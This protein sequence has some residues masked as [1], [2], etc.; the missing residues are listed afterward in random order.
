MMFCLTITQSAIRSP[1]RIQMQLRRDKLRL[2]ISPRGPLQR[3][4]GMGWRKKQKKTDKYRE[5]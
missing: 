1:S 5:Q 2:T 4:A 3:I